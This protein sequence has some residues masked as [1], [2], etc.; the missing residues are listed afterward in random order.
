MLHCMAK[1]NFIALS[2]LF[3]LF[4]LITPAFMPAGNN[5]STIEYWEYKHYAT[6]TKEGVTFVI[7]YYG[8]RRDGYNGFI[9]WKA[10]NKTN[11]DIFDF[12]INTRTYTLSDG[13]TV[14]IDPV[15]FISRATSA[16]NENTTQP[17]KVNPDDFKQTKATVVKVTVASPEMK[18]RFKEGGKHHEWNTLGEIEF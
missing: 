5:A 15:N 11:R 1:I 16:G 14:N 3:C 17:D 7:L 8:V 18:F 4:M 9:K 12:W 13:K 2:L 10:E 6:L